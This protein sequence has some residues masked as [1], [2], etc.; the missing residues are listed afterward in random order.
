MR[1]AKESATACCRIDTA[2]AGPMLVGTG[3]AGVFA[4]RMGWGGAASVG[5]APLCGEPQAEAPKQQ[6]PL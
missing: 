5:D 3:G 4:A 1:S 6:R 2:S